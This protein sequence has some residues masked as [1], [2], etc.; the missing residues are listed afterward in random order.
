MQAVFGFS[1]MEAAYLLLSAVLEPDKLLGALAWL[2]KPTDADE[3]QQL[4]HKMQPLL[5]P[6]CGWKGAMLESPSRFAT[7]WSLLKA[8]EAC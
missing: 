3:E 4:L 6:K 7:A 8:P 1:N 2:F 5:S